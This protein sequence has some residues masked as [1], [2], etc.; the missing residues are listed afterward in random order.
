MISVAR[1]VMWLLYIEIDAYTLS[2]IVYVASWIQSY[3]I[4]F[5]I[6]GDSQMLE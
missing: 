1:G 5:D 4:F 3:M 2:R 6:H